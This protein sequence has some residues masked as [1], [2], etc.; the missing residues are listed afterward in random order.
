MGMAQDHRDWHTIAA[1]EGT[2]EWRCPFDCIDPADMFEGP[3]DVFLV[4]VMCG[5]CRTH[6]EGAEGVRSCYGV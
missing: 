5:K 6:H 4:P 1:A 2:P 3:A